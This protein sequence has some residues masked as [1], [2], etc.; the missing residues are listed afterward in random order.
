M[1]RQFTTQ[2][3]L[4]DG[5]VRTIVDSSDPL[6]GE[7]TAC[8][9]TTLRALD[10]L[11]FVRIGPMGDRRVLRINDMAISPGGDVA[12]FRV[13]VL[14]SFPQP[15]DGQRGV[16]VVDLVKPAVV[17]QVQVMLSEMR[18]RPTY[19]RCNNTIQVAYVVSLD[20]R[21]THNVFPDVVLL[22]DHL[23]DSPG[24]FFVPLGMNSQ[25]VMEWYDVREGKHVLLTGRTGHGKST[26]LHAW[27]CSLLSTTPPAGL[28]MAF[29]DGQGLTF[30]PYRPLS[31]YLF[32]PVADTP[33]QCVEVVAQV[34]AEHQRRLELFRRARVFDV[35]CYNEKAEEPLPYVVLATD[36]LSTLKQLL[37]PT[38][39]GAR[40]LDRYLASLLAGARK[41]GIRVW[42]SVQYVKGEVLDTQTSA[43]AAMRVAFWNTPQGSRNSI[44]D[45][46]ASR[47]PVKARGRYI[48]DGYG[49]RRMVLQAPY[50]PP[51]ELYAWCSQATGAQQVRE[52]PVDEL[53]E[54]M[55]AYAM[56]ELGG[57]FPISMIGEVFGSLTSPRQIK[58]LARFLEGIGLLSPPGTDRNGLAQARRFRVETPDE[59]AEIL[60]KYPVRFVEREDG[61]FVLQI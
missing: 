49:D 6:F 54:R 32:A 39:A 43:Q 25:G 4:V 50:I 55:V 29:C 46:A 7:I 8:A 3:A 44:G 14:G 42:L 30:G 17:E 10:Q 36:E 34:E 58:K 19:V 37:G 16:R 26:L 22:A 59:A 20:D 1:S 13:D 47:L 41:V 15:P 61:K 18:G 31:D 45:D 48:L 52:Y 5:V 40:K 56:A 2:K 57:S 27:T 38:G 60:R 51:D 35:E 12:S 11:G 53:V 23:G 21:A 28:R 33:E 9:Q 24:P